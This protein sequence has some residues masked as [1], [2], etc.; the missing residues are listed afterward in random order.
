MLTAAPQMAA[1]EAPGFENGVFFESGR[2]G[3]QLINSAAPDQIERSA[4]LF[5]D[6]DEPLH[7]EWAPLR[8]AGTRR[9]LI[10]NVRDLGSSH[11]GCP[12]PEIRFRATVDVQC[13]REI[14]I[15]KLPVYKS[16]PFDGVQIDVPRHID[17]QAE[18]RSRSQT[19]A[20]FA[21]TADYLAAV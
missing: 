13:A 7:M 6:V 5:C 19:N 16:D 8:T 2:G 10:G 20:N 4:G 14:P 21:Q 3:R 17:E 9:E 1:H 18:I 11:I 12:A 15:K